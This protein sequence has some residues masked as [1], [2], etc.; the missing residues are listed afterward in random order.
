M[1][2]RTLTQRRARRRKLLRM[3]GAG[4]L[5][6]ALGAAWIWQRTLPLERIEVA[7][8]VHAPTDEVIALTRAVPDSVS[9]FAL[10]PALLADRAQRHPW[11][12]AAT[13]RRLPTGTLRIAVEERIPVVLVLDGAG[14]PSHFLDAAGFAMPAAAASPAL[15][16]VPVL[17]G[18]PPYHPTQPVDSPG[19]PSFLTA[20]ATADA[21]TQA[22]VSEIRWRPRPTLWTTPVAAHGSLPVR[23]D[24]AGD[25]ADQL[26]RLR[27][28]WNQAVL[29]RPE[30]RFDTI[31]LRFDGQVVTR[32]AD[33][34]APLAPTD[35]TAA[36]AAPA[37]AE[38]D[39]SAATP[40][41]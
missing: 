41:V 28:F 33:P 1:A 31:D 23:L 32:E 4:L 26:R 3:A 22:L 25:P 38:T 8:A 11:V 39:A 19:L 12:E 30:V 16:D 20:L 37:P 5:V 13:V 7:G 2:K 9:L 21:A 34:D 40:S 29:P 36:P 17:T 35:S 10:S 24:P 15:Y 27:A 6:L 18:A 14:R